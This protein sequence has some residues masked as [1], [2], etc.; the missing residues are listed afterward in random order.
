[1]TLAWQQSQ[2]RWAKQEESKGFLQAMHFLRLASG[3]IGGSGRGGRILFFLS[4][5]SPPIH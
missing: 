5:N 3:L 4:M 1:M 2:K